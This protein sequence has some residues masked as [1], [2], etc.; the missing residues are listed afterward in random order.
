MKGKQ[1]KNQNNA[2]RQKGNS[3]PPPVLVV[4]ALTGKRRWERNK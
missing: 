1:N 2:S 3:T 4:D